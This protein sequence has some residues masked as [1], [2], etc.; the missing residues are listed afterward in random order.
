MVLA[1]L[2]VLRTDEQ[3]ASDDDVQTD[4]HDDGDEKEQDELGDFEGGVPDGRTLAGEHQ[5]AELDVGGGRLTRG[6][7]QRVVDGGRQAADQRHRPDDGQHRHDSAS[8]ADDVRVDR[9]NDRDVSKNRTGNWSS[10]LHH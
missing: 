8:T 1:T 9:M 7:S 6:T 2:E 5:H 3:F 10:Y 4:L